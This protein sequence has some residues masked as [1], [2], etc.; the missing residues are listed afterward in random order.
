MPDETVVAADLSATVPTDSSAVLPPDENEVAAAPEEVTPEP[1]TFE[2]W[3]DYYKAKVE[4][5]E[6]LRSDYESHLEGVRSESRQK[7]MSDAQSRLQPM[8]QTYRG[9]AQAA[10]QGFQ[11]IAQSLNKAIKEGAW[12]AETVSE[13]FR[14]NPAAWDAWNG[15][16]YAGGAGQGAKDLVT[17]MAK[18]LNDDNLAQQFAQR[19]DA[20]QTGYD[21]KEAVSADLVDAIIRSAKEQAEKPLKRQIAKLEAQLE[22]GKAISRQ[23]K[24]P[25]SVQGASGGGSYKTRQDAVA[26]HT[27]GEI[28]Y[29][30]MRELNRTLPDGS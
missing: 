20:A 14:A 18:S 2:T 26:A 7:G 4:A 17:L 21:T 19:I 11:G 9:L 28:S 12:D 27:R 30:R 5:N 6:T 25:D 16:S 13:L 8:V 3:E 24:G 22:G 23:G 15:L 1:E 10:T 29:E